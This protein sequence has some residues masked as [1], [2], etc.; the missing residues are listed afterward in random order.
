MTYIIINE[1]HWKGKLKNWLHDYVM[2]SVYCSSVIH[3]DSETQSLSSSVIIELEYF[4]IFFHDRSSE[5]NRKV[6]FL[7]CLWNYTDYNVGPPIL[8]LF[9]LVFDELIIENQFIIIENLFQN[10]V[11]VMRPGYWGISRPRKSN[12]PSIRCI[13]ASSI[14]SANWFHVVWRSMLNRYLK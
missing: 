12:F 4:E 6:D 11:W 2:K 14:S 9:F 1:W 7:S 13:W 10:S 8:T 3:F 5:M